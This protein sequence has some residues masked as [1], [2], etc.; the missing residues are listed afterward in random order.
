MYQKLSFLII[1]LFGS[2]SYFGYL[3]KPVLG[4]IKVLAQDEVIVTILVGNLAVGVT[5]NTGNGICM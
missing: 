5:Y 4:F 2:F 1:I 3:D